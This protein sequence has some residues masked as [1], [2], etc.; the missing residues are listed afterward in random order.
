[1]VKLVF[2]N[3]C[4]FSLFAFLATQLLIFLPAHE[5]LMIYPWTF[6][7]LLYTPILGDFTHIPGFF[8]FLTWSSPSVLLG[9]PCGSAGKESACNAGDLGL[10]PGLER[11]P[12]R[13]ER[14]P[15]PVFWPG[16]VLG[17]YSPWGQKE[18]DITE[19]LSLSLSPYSWLPNRYVLAQVCTVNLASIWHTQFEYSSPHDV[20][21]T[22][23]SQ[24]SSVPCC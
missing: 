5:M 22:H 2:F 6:F 3:F 18:S 23:L 20:G 21:E 15:T 14:L 16:E 7:F 24:V 8:I 1:M 19:R 10:I 17:L 12:W 11:F 9:F 13:R 4:E